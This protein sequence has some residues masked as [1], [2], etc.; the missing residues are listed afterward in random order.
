MTPEEWDTYDVRHQ[1]RDMGHE[2]EDIRPRAGDGRQ[3]SPKS[4]SENRRLSGAKPVLKPGFRI[5]SK[6]KVPS[7]KSQISGLIPLLACALS[8]LCFSG[9]PPTGRVAFEPAHELYVNSLREFMRGNY[10]GAY[11]GYQQAV[12]TDPSLANS[13]HQ[14]S[15]LYGW[16]RSQ[17]QA[18]DASL[19]E[20]QRQLLLTPQQFARRQALLSLAVDTE[21]DTIQ[22]FG[23]G[24]APGSI[25][26][27]EQKRLLAREAALTSAYAWVARL[28]TWTKTGVEGSFDVSQ[29]LF[30]VRPLKEAWIGEEVFAI[31]V[32]APLRKNAS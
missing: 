31:K 18:E 11:H 23:I 13:S 27:P 24:L 29:E 1:M 10:P 12:E 21:R 26:H 4:P 8:I 7:L 15:I 19:L 5:G 22:V 2:T 20:A 28:A 9:C 14:S 17:S 32:G 25:S 3:E 30:D 6:P 16:V